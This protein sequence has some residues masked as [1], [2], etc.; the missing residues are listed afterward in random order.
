MRPFAARTILN[1]KSSSESAIRAIR[2]FRLSPG[3][4]PTSRSVPIQLVI[5]ADEI[6]PNPKVNTLNNMLPQARH[7][8]LL[9]LDSDIRVGPDFIKAIYRGTSH[10]PRVLSPVSIAPGR[11]PEFLQSWKPQGF[12]RNLPRVC[13]WPKWPAGFHLPSEQPLPSR[14]KRLETIGGFTALAPYLADDYMIGN[15][16]RK[17]GLPVKL[18][19]Y[20][21]ETVLSRLSLK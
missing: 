13:S 11:R 4:A 21:V 16:V 1:S 2:L 20:V 10:M 3:C 14:K 9:M 7:E 6:G 17:A 5:S 8:T 18:S 12:P 15:L 19:R